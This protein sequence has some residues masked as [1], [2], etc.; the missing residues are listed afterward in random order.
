MGDIGQL[1]LFKAPNLREEGKTAMVRFPDIFVSG[2]SCLAKTKLNMHSAKNKSCIQR[3]DCSAQTTVT[4]QGVRNFMKRARPLWTCLENLV[5]LDELGEDMA[6]S[7][8]EYILQDMGKEQF[9]AAALDVECAE[10]GSW[11]VRKRKFFSMLDGIS[12]RNK[13]LHFHVDIV[14]QPAS[15]SSLHR[16]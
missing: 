7:D 2:F 15:S 16:H 4:Y 5:S 3:G 9:Q 6:I 14:S 11:P 12:P 13:A 1:M 8:A 10:Y